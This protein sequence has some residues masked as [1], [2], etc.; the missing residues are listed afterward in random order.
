MIMRF[1]F[2]L[3]ISALSAG[4]AM[5]P[6]VSQST[7][8]TF[9][10]GVVVAA[11]PT[12]FVETRYDVGAYREATAPAIRHEGHAIFRRTRVPA[13]ASD[14][15]ETVPRTSY[16]TASFAP[17][18]ANEELTAELAIQKKITADLSAMQGTLAE[19]EQ[20]MKAQYSTLVKQSTETIKVREQLE[21]ERSR[22]R[23]VTP[24]EATPVP[25]AAPTV[26]PT[27]NADV[28]W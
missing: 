17:L 5:Q 18:P 12:K 9:G 15:L 8:P 14:D 6:R 1:T 26:V 16:S 24:A 27:P 21:A 22:L 3:L 25:A 19:V 11:R 20:K 2:A 23:R 28:K 13:S 10:P 4:C 7:L